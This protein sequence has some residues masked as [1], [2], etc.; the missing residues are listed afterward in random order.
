LDNLSLA[1]HPYLIVNKIIDH[2]DGSALIFNFS[3]Y[4]DGEGTETKYRKNIKILSQDISFEWFKTQLEEL[5]SK[6][7]IGLMSL[8]DGVSVKYQMPF[9]DFKSDNIANIRNTIRL[10]KQNGSLY[11]FKSGSSYHGYID[12]LLSDDE[13]RTFMGKLLLLLP[14][15]DVGKIIDLRWVGHSLQKNYAV[16]R[17]SKKEMIPTLV[18]VIELAS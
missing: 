6:Q 16:L 8:V 9:I 11:L 4:E 3:I 2:N 10:I 15:S 14:S 7:Q 17:W 18:E 1:T 13:W 12:C 5:P